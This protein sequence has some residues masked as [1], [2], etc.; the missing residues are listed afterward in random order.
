MIRDWDE[1]NLHMD[2]SSIGVVCSDIDM[3]HVTR[4]GFLVLGEIKNSRGTFSDGQRRLLS[5][6]VDR[7]KG[8]GTVLYITHD[9]DVH[10]GDS[11]VDISTCLVEEYYWQ[12]EWITPYKFITVKDAMKKLEERT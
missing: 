12:G 10:Q 7:H 2:Y 3:L 11:V 9:R 6:I 1:H 4:S 5:G 8:G